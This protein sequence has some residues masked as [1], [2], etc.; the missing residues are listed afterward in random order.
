MKVEFKIFGEL[1]NLTQNQI[2]AFLEYMDVEFINIEDYTTSTEVVTQY[3]FEAGLESYPITI[4]HFILDDGCE[5]DLTIDSD[6]NVESYEF[7]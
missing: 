5:Y 3:D 6:L 2:S 4:H 1:R 7:E